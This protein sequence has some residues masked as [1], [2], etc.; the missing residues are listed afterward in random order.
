[1]ERESNWI[2]IYQVFNSFFLVSAVLLGFFVSWV[3]ISQITK[4]QKRPG[5][6]L[7]EL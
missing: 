1:M 2:F 3:L 5:I 4:L 6:N 7:K